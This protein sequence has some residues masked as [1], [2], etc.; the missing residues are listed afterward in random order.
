MG[1]KK[2]QK[3]TIYGLVEGDR[4]EGFINHLLEVF[5]FD[6]NPSTNVTLHNNK[7]G[8]FCSMLE[9][10][11]KQNSRDVLFLLC[12]EDFDGSEEFKDL[13]KIGW[14]VKTEMFEKH[15]LKDW[16]SKINIKNK[17]PTLIISNPVCFEG[18]ILSILGEE[19]QE[20]NVGNRKKQIKGLKNSFEGIK[21]GLSDAEFFK[22]VL[23]KEFLE[24]SKNKELQLL[25]SALSGNIKK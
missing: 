16:Q 5:A 2:K 11:M 1:K 20:F 21:N 7:G 13:D 14:K 9:K 24:E 19:L 22:K 18:L 17:K 10:L 3:I 6:K 4:E 12:D 25:L 15:K 8:T 23:S